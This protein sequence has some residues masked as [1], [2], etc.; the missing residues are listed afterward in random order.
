ML[1]IYKREFRSYMRSMIGP[2]FIS[3]L[4]LFTGVCVTVFNLF[5]G[6][7]SFQYALDWTSIAFIVVIP[8]ITMRSLTEDRA[9]R[10]SNLLFS[11]P[12]KLS[13][14]IL[15]KFFAVATVFALP[16]LVMLTYPVILSAY[17]HMYYAASYGAIF[18]LFLLGLA[19]ISISMFISSLT[20]SQI[21]AA[22]ISFG[23]IL[24]LLALPLFLGLI[25]KSPIVSFVCFILL[26][27]AVAALVWRLTA[28]T[29]AGLITAAAGV[30]PLSAAYIAD[31][32]LYRGGFAKVM[33]SLSLYDRFT[34]LNSGI[35]DIPS[36]VYLLSV[37][38]FFLYLSVQSL[39]KRRWS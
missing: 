37:T 13:H 11:L 12:I 34:R 25:P 28:N 39:E 20:E 33:G 31:P 14:I 10:T 26:A 18:A 5:G 21:I 6:I 1:A 27:L 23:V 4:L 19:L 9:N 3:F 38:F 15:G 36:V 22:V 16:I 32:S 24:S 8:I 17:G 30:I 35:F 2:V 7:S 29:G